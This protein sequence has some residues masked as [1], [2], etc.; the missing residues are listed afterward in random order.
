[1]GGCAPPR[2]CPE[3]VPIQCGGEM[4]EDSSSSEYQDQGRVCKPLQGVGPVCVWVCVYV[5]VC[6]CV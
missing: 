1:M 5:G 4:G 6:V 2:G 3:G